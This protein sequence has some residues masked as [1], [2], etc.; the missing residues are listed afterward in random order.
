MGAAAETCAAVTGQGA[1]AVQ[2]CTP[3]LKLSLRP[4]FGGGLL[5]GG[6]AIEQARWLGGEMMLPS[7]GPRSAR[8]EPH[9]TMA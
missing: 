8:A 2:R 4:S 3:W 9:E 5:G 1:G 6:H 7:P